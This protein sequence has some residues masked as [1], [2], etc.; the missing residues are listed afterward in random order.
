[1]FFT[2]GVSSVSI[3][4]R[5]RVRHS[6]YLAA[7]LVVE[8]TTPRTAITKDISALG[9]LLLTRANLDRGESV[10]LKIYP[11]GDEMRSVEVRGKVVRLEELVDGERG[12]WRNK[13]A[14]AF[15]QPQ[16]EMAQ[17]FEEFAKEQAKLFAPKRKR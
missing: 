17:E 6:V 3:E 10:V 16:P 2:L 5:Q 1:M 13:V 9:L 14:F 8:G 7:E 12:I 11:P 15:D 4:R